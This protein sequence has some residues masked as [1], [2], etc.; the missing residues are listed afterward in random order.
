MDK[1]SV[2]SGCKNCVCTK[3]ANEDCNHLSCGFCSAQ[4][5]NSDSR[6]IKCPEYKKELKGE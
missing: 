3:C 5:E 4:K 2:L 1:L 6:V